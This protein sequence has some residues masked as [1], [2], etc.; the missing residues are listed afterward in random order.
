[1]LK[2]CELTG[3]ESEKYIPTL[4]QMED[5]GRQGSCMTA[6]SP[7]QSEIVR[8][9]SKSTPLELISTAIKSATSTGNSTPDKAYKPDTDEMLITP[10]N[11]T[12]NSSCLSPRQSSEEAKDTS[13]AI[14]SPL[15]L[16][17]SPTFQGLTSAFQYVKTS[18]KDIDNVRRK[19]SSSMHLPQGSP[20]FG[21]SMTPSLGIIR[22]IVQLPLLFS[23]EQMSEEGMLPQLIKVGSECKTSSTTGSSLLKMS[24]VTMRRKRSQPEP[25]A[26]AAMKLEEDSLEDDEDS[27][28]AKEAGEIA[29]ED[30]KDVEVF[31]C[32]HCP[33]CFTTGQALGGHMSRKH[34]GK[35]VKY[36]YKKDVRKKREFERMKLFLAKKRYFSS[37]NFDYEQLVKTPR[38]KLQAK[39]LINRSRIKKIK[40]LLTD[41]EVYNYFD[42][43]Q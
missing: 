39:T 27:K 20:L 13:R 28:E 4:V 23:E 19:I 2:E 25:A 38:G 11:S 37:L 33:K 6:D 10:F 5:Q 32:K 14:G 16:K 29:A 21:T 9:I 3:K 40:S 30:C 43:K 15:Q 18:V 35:S 8:G 31:K 1:M 34:S 12:K 42:N 26:S 36:N 7:I 22:P 24:S 41:E 17:G